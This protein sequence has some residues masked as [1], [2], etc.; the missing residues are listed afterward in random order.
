MLDN[1]ALNVLESENGEPCIQTNFES[2]SDNTNSDNDESSKDSNFIKFYQWYINT[3]IK[4][5][6]KIIWMHIL[7][8]IQLF[9]FT[10]NK[11]EHSP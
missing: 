1:D 5:N 10:D 9:Y 8:S 3:S 2:N 4:R 7:L 11:A 6:P